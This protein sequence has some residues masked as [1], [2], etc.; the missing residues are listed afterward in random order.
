MGMMG[1]NRDSSGDLPKIVTNEI[2]A[3][4]VAPPTAEIVR[5]DQEQ[6]TEFQ[7][8]VYDTAMQ[9]L[10]D[11]DGGDEE[12]SLTPADIAEEI[13]DGDPYEYVYEIN[14]GA[15]RVFDKD[16]VG[17]KYDIG[18]RKQKRVKAKVMDSADME[19]II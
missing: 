17:A 16:K 1:M 15:Q 19:E 7:D 2:E 11:D 4:D 8:E 13:L 3:V 6:E 10:A 18:S 14:N 12:K 5:P 9:E